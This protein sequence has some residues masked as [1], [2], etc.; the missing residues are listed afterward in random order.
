MLLGRQPQTN[1]TEHQSSILAHRT[2]GEIEVGRPR[3]GWDRLSSELQVGPKSAPW[4]SHS[5]RTSDF[6]GGDV[7]M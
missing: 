7:L 4:M 6:L 3:L 1:A 5:P 2:V